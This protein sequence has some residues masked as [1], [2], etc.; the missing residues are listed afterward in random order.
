MVSVTS[1]SRYETSAPHYQSRFLMYIR[2]LIPQNSMELAVA[3][4]IGIG[5]GQ[6]MREMLQNEGKE[7]TWNTLMHLK[8]MFGH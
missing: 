2:V 8:A 1:A 3:F 6:V 4:Q 7:N 5:S